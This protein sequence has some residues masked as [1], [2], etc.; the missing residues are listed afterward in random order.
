MSREEL[1]DDV[2]RFLLEHF[3]LPYIHNE[4]ILLEHLSDTNIFLLAEHQIQN[5]ISICSF[6][7]IA[8]IWLQ[9]KYVTTSVK[10]I[11]FCIV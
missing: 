2:I 8:N 10:E 11:G 7:Q 6:V 4:R 9:L 3:E 5:K 1:S